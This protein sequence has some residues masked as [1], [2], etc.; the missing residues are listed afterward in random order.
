MVFY[1]ALI[2]FHVD[3]CPGTAGHTA[4][5][6]TYTCIH[7]PAGLPRFFSGFRGR[8]TCSLLQCFFTDYISTFPV[9]E[10]RKDMAI[11]FT[12]PKGILYQTI[13]LTTR[14]V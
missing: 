2:I 14:N 4:L 13:N 9:E 8:S 3:I 5:V 10:A 6:Y 7:I 11:V 12:L 1:V